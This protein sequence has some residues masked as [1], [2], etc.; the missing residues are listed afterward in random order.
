[1]AITNSDLSCVPAGAASTGVYVA[2]IIDVATSSRQFTYNS[3]TVT[4]GAVS[5]SN[6]AVLPNGETAL[7]TLTAVSPVLAPDGTSNLGPV[8]LTLT[9]NA[10]DVVDASSPMEYVVSP[11][12]LVIVSSA[13]S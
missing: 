1:M 10:S 13:A 11:N 2:G 8:R 3:Y 7:P 6:P 5:A 9:P 4:S 12:A